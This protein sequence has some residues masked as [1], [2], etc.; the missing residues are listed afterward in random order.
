MWNIKNKTKKKETKL[1]FM[2]IGGKGLEAGGQ[3][4]GDRWY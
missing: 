4:Y 2:V 3:L 1:R